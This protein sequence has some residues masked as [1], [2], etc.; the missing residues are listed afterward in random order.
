MRAGQKRETPVED[1]ST[2]LVAQ[3]PPEG[4]TDMTLAERCTLA[5]LLVRMLGH[6]LR[7][8]Y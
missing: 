6:S 8:S 5:W 2:E 7:D 3:D 1:A 4:A